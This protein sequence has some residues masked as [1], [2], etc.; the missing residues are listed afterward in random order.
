LTAPSL[1]FGGHITGLD[2]RAGV[3]FRDEAERAEERILGPWVPDSGTE[4]DSVAPI[5]SHEQAD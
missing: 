3:V 4:S 5:W 2:A 1:Y